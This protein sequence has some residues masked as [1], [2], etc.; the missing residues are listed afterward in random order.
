MVVVRAPHEQVVRTLRAAGVLASVGPTS[1][2]GWTCVW[3]DHEDAIDPHEWGFGEYL[4]VE[5]MSSTAR[6]RACEAT[7]TMATL[8]ADADTAVDATQAA[9]MLAR[10]F[11]AP[12]QQAELEGLL[13]GGTADLDSV[14]SGLEDLLALP[15]VEPGPQPG[16]VLS[17]SDPTMVRMAAE[18]AGPASLASLADGW[19]AI[20]P[21]PDDEEGYE[22]LAGAI[23]TLGR[24]REHTV[25]LWREGGRSGVQIWRRSDL[26]ATWSW[27]GWEFVD[28]D[29]MLESVF[30]D[31]CASLRPELHLPTLR[32]L[33]RR[34]ASGDPLA[35]FVGLLGLP[36]AVLG[37]VDTTAAGEAL[38]GGELVERMPARRAWWSAVNSARTDPEPVTNKLLY[39]AFAVATVIACL[40]SLAMTLLG[41]AV[42]ATDGAVIDQQGHSL[43][44]WLSVVFFGLLTAILVPTSVFRFRRLRARDDA[45]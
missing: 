39:G 15:E 23:S 40:L 7:G 24:R 34:Q 12:D 21:V 44:D 2:S 14:A 27:G 8:W 45:P 1:G 30:C 26:A 4:S 13:A 16:V 3:L 18:I 31:E 28:P 6:V 17:R 37:M 11:D 25:V 41:I 38:P 35:E 32:A 20:A 10:M 29:W 5:E 36:E 33:L 19:L 9:A 22:A 43:A 42:I